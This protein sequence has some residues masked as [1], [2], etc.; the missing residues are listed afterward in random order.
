MSCDKEGIVWSLFGSNSSSNIGKAVPCDDNTNEQSS[1]SNNVEQCR[2]KGETRNVKEKRLEKANG[3]CFLLPS[4]YYL[5]VWFWNSKK[6]I[7]RSACVH[8]MGCVPHTMLLSLVS[9]SVSFI[10]LMYLSYNY[11]EVRKSLFKVWKVGKPGTI[12]TSN[13]IKIRINIY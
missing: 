11:W 10:Y 8:W 1:S 3:S 6:I 12:Y 7:N 2:A 9:V 13:L 4:L 5:L